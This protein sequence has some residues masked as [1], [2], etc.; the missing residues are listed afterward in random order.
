MIDK[1]SC[2]IDTKA[3]RFHRVH[4]EDPRARPHQDGIGRISADMVA[5]AVGSQLAGFDVFVPETA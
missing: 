1:V 4:R 2:T 3:T 5:T